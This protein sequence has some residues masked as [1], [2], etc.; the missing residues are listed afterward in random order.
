M[1][2]L[3]GLTHP[4]S[5]VPDRNQKGE[6]DRDGNGRKKMGGSDREERKSVEAGGNIFCNK[7]IEF[8]I[9]RPCSRRRAVVATYLI[10]LT[11]GRHFI[12]MVG[13]SSIVRVCDIAGGSFKL[14]HFETEHVIALETGAKHVAGIDVVVAYNKD[15]GIKWYVDETTRAMKTQINHLCIHQRPGML[16]L[17]ILPRLL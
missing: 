1:Q 6:K 15:S 17:V 16:L 4:K 14:C 11:L 8:L 9:L 5:P 13:W 7:K 3:R 12:G 2:P 10:R